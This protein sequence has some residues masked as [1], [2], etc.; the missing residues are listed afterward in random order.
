MS[1][2]NDSAFPIPICN[3]P[4]AYATEPGLTKRELFTAMA[5]QGLLTNCSPDW[6]TGECTAVVASRAVYEADTLLKELERNRTEYD[7]RVAEKMPE[8]VWINAHSGAGASLFSYTKKSDADERLG[9][10]MQARYVRADE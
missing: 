6:S 4:G 9:G 8:T 10:R 5:M 7:N 1:D 3:E 2:G